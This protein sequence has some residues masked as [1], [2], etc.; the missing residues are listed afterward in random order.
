MRKTKAVVATAIAAGWLAG[1]AATAQA[2]VISFS[3]SGSGK[4]GPF[5]AAATITTGPDAITVFL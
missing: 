4:D 5:A 1:A 2:S 3:G